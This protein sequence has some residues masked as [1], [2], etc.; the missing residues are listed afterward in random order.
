MVYNI[1]STAPSSAH[2][3]VNIYNIDSTALQCTIH[4]TGC[5]KILYSDPPKTLLIAN[6]VNRIPQF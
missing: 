6:R 3:V 1:D 2:N 4:I 5:Y